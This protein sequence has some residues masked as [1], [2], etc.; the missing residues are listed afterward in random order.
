MS[1]PVPVNLAVEDA[2][3]ETVLRRILERIDNPFA[4][5]SAFSQGGI[6]YLRRLIRGLNNAAKGV[7]FLVLA[8]LDQID[9]APTALDDW[10]PSGAY[11]NLMLRFAVREVEAWLIADREAL[12]TF[13]GVK[14]QGVPLDVESITDPKRCLVGIARTSSRS[15]IRQDIVPRAASTAVVGRNYNVRMQ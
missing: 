11:P 5:G 14:Q 8:D 9:C 2:I 1:S 12:A 10:L 7:P 3:S 6:G 4:V 13:L 15:D